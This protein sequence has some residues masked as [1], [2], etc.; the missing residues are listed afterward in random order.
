MDEHSKR[1]EPFVGEWSIRVAFQGSPPVEGGRVAFEWMAG[2]RFLI[3]RWEAP[4][5]EA[6]DGLGRVLK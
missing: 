6:P 2:T 5:P 1:L 4:V 3:Q